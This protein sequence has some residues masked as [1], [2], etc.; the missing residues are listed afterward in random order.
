MH[1]ALELFAG[2]ADARCVPEHFIKDSFTDDTD[3]L[4]LFK[5]T[6]EMG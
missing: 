1:P 4:L 6:E 2:H 5:K 3:K